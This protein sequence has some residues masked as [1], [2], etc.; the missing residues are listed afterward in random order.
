V[1]ERVYDSAEAKACE[2][3]AFEGG[4]THTVPSTPPGSPPRE[5]VWD[6]DG[7]PNLS[8]FNPKL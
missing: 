5:F 1:H 7:N 3:L 4:Q 6:L 8:Q 2:S